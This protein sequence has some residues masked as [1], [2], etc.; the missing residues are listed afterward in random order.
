[1]K[2]IILSLALLLGIISASFSQRYLEYKSTDIII[3]TDAIGQIGC[4]A[5]WKVEIPTN[6]VD[7]AIALLPQIQGNLIYKDGKFNYTSVAPINNMF[8]IM[9]SAK[10]ESSDVGKTGSQVISNFALYMLYAANPLNLEQ[11]YWAIKQD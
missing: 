9:D 6:M 5:R 7:T 1:M 10:V 4:Q 3:T 8:A 11:K 2:K